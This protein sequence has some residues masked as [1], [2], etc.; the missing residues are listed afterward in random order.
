MSIAES[1]RIAMDRGIKAVALKPSVGQ[2]KETMLVE[3]SAN[4]S[5]KITDGGKSLSI[6][7]EKEYG[8]GG[9]TPSPGFYVRA[10]LGACLAQGYL[11]W[12]AQLDVPI[13]KVSVKIH[14][15]YDMRGNLAIDPDIRGG[16]TAL[17]YI[18]RI[19]SAEGPESIQKVVDK[20]DATDYVLDIFA[21]ELVMTRELHI[22]PMPA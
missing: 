9:A 6:D 3:T 2:G 13:G 17:H 21:G 1:I 22:E 4:G 12:A 15:E 19:E 11:V 8:G 7:L 16:I 20:V 18:V 5:V 14:S 10:A